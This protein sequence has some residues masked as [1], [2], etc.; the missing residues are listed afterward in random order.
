MG[1]STVSF[2]YSKKLPCQKRPRH[3]KC[4]TLH[5]NQLLVGKLF[6]LNVLDKPREVAA[7]APL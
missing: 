2:V 7:V 3:Y 1:S 6:R 4:S 5:P